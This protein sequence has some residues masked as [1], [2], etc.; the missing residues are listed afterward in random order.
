MTRRLKPTHCLRGHEY[1]PQTSLWSIGN[2]GK[3]QRGCRTCR[4]MRVRLRYHT[5]EAFRGAKLA[6]VA[7]YYKQIKTLPSEHQ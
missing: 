7:A 3:P 5:D 2:N 4:N 6:S 1:T